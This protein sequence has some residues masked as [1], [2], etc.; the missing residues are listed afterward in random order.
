[1]RAFPSMIKTVVVSTACL[2][3]FGAQAQITKCIDESGQVTYSD[4]DCGRGNAI[5]YLD[6]DAVAP[7]LPAAPVRAV[8][9]MAIDVAPLR[10]SAW[11]AMPPVLRHPSKDA[12]TVSEAREALAASD[13]G[14]IAI[15]T[16][17]MLSR[18]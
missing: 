13:R 18:R 5:G 11:A 16:Q 1:M 8:P 6:I 9:P 10:T 15:R 2:L 7:A 12:A 3:T 17:K 14:L 4:G